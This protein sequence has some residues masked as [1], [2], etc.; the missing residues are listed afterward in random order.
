MNLAILSPKFVTQTLVY[1][2]TCLCSFKLDVWNREVLLPN[3]LHILVIHDVSGNNI[4]VN[5]F[6]KY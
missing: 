1:C 3:T 2:P 5:M 6:V 4:H